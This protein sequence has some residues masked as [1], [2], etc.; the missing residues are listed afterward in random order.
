MKK[1]TLHKGLHKGAQNRPIPGA[2]GVHTPLSRNERECV[3]PTPPELARCTKVHA[4][5]LE[6]T[7]V[8]DEPLC[9][10]L[11]QGD[12][13]SAVSEILVGPEVAGL[14]LPI[15]VRL[16][17]IEDSRSTVLALVWLMAECRW[18]R[19]SEIWRA[20]RLGVLPEV[21]R[22]LDYANPPGNVFDCLEAA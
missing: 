11:I 22:L 19:G 6:C 9:W 5:G 4:Q 14:Y 15:Q 18:A 16:G 1:A 21:E 10:Q 3:H 13:R 17:L 12:G 2:R 8:R 7:T 20:E